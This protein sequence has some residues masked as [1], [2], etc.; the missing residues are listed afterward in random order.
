MMRSGKGRARGSGYDQF[1]GRWSD[2]AAGCVWFFVL[3]VG[4][5]KNVWS[6][7]WRGFFFFSLSVF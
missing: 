2:G 3:Y 1:H 4:G 6:G 5:K 7:N